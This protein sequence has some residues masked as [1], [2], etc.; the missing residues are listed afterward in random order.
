[1]DAPFATA[2]VN[3]I[4]IESLKEPARA[5]R[6]RGCVSRTGLGVR[7]AAAIT[8]FALPPPLFTGPVPFAFPPP[9]VGTPPPPN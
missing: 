5:N 3:Q 9:F 8:P 6:D 4:A 7:L 2:A 1:M